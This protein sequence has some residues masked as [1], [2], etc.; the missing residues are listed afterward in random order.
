[1]KITARIKL[2]C[3]N[4]IMEH[5][6]VLTMTKDYVMVML[7]YCVPN[8]LDFTCALFVTLVTFTKIMNDF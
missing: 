7:N 8:A 1:M 3:L 2:T 6:N 4:L 5:L